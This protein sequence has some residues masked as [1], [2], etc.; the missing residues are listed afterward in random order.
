MRSLWKP[1]A[2]LKNRYQQPLMLASPKLIDGDCNIQGIADGYWQDD[3]G[4]ICAGYDMHNSE[5]T[6]LTLAYEDITHFLV[7]E[8]PWTAIELEKFEHGIYYEQ[9][10]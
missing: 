6:T 8:G 3:E 1:I 5:Y 4:W 7:P 9:D 2:E 10:I